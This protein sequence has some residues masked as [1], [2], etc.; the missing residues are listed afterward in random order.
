MST[1]FTGILASVL[2]ALFNLN[3]LSDMISIGT[4]L[5]F[6]MVCS[7]ASAST[8]GSADS[9]VVF[10]FALECYLFVTHHQH[11]NRKNGAELAAWR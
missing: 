11:Q 5:A 2:A 3:L 1:I 10:R 4:L 9:E 8:N 6:S 7:C